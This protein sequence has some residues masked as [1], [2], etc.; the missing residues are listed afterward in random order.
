M[1]R[2]WKLLVPPPPP[3]PPLWRLPEPPLNDWLCVARP[4]PPLSPPPPAPLLESSFLCRSAAA[5]AQSAKVSSVQRTPRFR[6]VV[7]RIFPIASRQMARIRLSP[8]PNQWR[9]V[10]VAGVARNDCRELSAL[11]ATRNG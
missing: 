9:W 1:E 7:K 4:P 3:P 11:V 8:V 2:F 10:R 6:R 5:V